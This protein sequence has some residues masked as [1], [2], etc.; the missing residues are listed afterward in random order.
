[1]SHNENIT[2][3]GE[4]TTDKRMNQA[5]KQQMWIFPFFKYYIICVA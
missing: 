2:G 1:M 3:N 4:K 5:I